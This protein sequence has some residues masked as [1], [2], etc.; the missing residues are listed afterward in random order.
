MQESK[1][2]ALCHIRNSAFWISL[3]RMASD[4]SAV[5]FTY[6]PESKNLA[7]RLFVNTYG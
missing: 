4:G 6:T 7:M 5:S 2:A 1:D 3:T